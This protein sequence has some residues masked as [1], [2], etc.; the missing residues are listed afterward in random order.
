MKIYV[1]D[2]LVNETIYFELNDLNISIPET[3]NNDVYVIDDTFFSSYDD[4]DFVD[5]LQYF[6]SSKSGKY[7]VYQR[8]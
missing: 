5:E 7:Y 3:D 6:N 8:F 2:S 1:N 4:Y